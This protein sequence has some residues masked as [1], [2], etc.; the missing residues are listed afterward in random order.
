MKK[1]SKITENGQTQFEGSDRIREEYIINTS[2]ISDFEIDRFL[3]I[4]EE[5]ENMGCSVN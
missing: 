5:L 3:E 4:I 2:L 1:F